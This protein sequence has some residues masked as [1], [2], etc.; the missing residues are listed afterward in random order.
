MTKK[1]LKVKGQQPKKKKVDCGAY[2]VGLTQGQDLDEKKCLLSSYGQ[3]FQTLPQN[4]QPQQHSQNHRPFRVPTKRHIRICSHPTARN[5][6]IIANTTY[7]S[8]MRILCSKKKCGCFLGQTFQ[9][10][11]VFEEEEEWRWRGGVFAAAE[12][13]QWRDCGIRSACP[14]TGCQAKGRASGGGEAHRFL[15]CG[16]EACCA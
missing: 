2:N 6:R 12:Y 14:S 5:K 3:N 10:S 16:A 7:V 1:K 13:R 4:W 11:R 8:V 9:A 15:C